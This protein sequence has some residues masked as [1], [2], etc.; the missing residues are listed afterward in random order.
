MLQVS[1]VKCAVE[2]TSMGSI[3]LR[4]FVGLI[5]PPIGSG[6]QGAGE[7]MVENVR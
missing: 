4:L 7:R 3:A 5:K 6:S 2:R 1:S